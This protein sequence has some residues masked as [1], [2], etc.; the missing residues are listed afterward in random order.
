MGYTKHKPYKRS[1]VKCK[2]CSLA[3]N[4]CFQN[5]LEE[6]RYKQIKKKVTVEYIHV[7][8]PNCLHCKMEK[9]K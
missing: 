9:E 5:K 1:G 4:K 3:V 7:D 8:N 6:K 2:G